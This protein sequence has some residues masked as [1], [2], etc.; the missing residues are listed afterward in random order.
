MLTD[1]EMQRLLDA[2]VDAGDALS[3]Q[4]GGSAPHVERY[5]LALDAAL[6][7]LVE[8][9]REWRLAWVSEHERDDALKTEAERL[10]YYEMENH[11]NP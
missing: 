6:P 8:E 3:Y 11:E 9:V 10:A 7:K 2:R 5:V 4:F 1:A